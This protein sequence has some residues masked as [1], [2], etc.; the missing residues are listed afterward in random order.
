MSIYLPLFFITK[1]S[2]A[3]SEELK[4]N[5]N[6]SK[7]QNNQRNQP[8]RAGEKSKILKEWIKT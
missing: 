3:A 2:A 1:I 5:L 7:G 8:E 4:N 6:K